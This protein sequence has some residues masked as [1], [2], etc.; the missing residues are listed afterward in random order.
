M[1]VRCAGGA[2]QGLGGWSALKVPGLGG[3]DCYQ[4]GKVPGIIVVVELCR[5]LGGCL[6]QQAG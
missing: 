5:Y 3:L 4:P 2:K 6:R 1:E